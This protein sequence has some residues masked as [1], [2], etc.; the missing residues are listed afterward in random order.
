MPWPWSEQAHLLLAL[1]ERF[2]KRRTGEHQLRV[3]LDR[4]RL[5]RQVDLIIRQPPE[6]RR[7]GG[8]DQREL[9][10][11]EER[12]ELEQIGALQDGVAQDLLHLHR[13]LLVRLLI[14]LTCQAV[15]VALYAVERET[16]LRARHRIDRHQRRMREALIEVFDH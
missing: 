8:I 10:R 13:L 7:Y 14:D 5:R 12:L 2:A 11:K 3:P 1:G 16:E 6:D 15:P 9:V 4:L